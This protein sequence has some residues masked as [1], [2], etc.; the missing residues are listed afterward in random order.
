MKKK[1]YSPPVLKSLTPEEAKK[2]ILAGRNCSEEE[3][4][5]FLN[6]RGPKSHRTRDQYDHPA[7]GRDDN[8]K[9]SA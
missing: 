4:T 2:L 3:A 8:Q 7:G 5:E 1:A 9:L 6:S